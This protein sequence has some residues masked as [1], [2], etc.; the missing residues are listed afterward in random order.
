MKDIRLKLFLLSI[1]VLKIYNLKI[2]SICPP[3][4]LRNC[5]DKKCS[6]IDKS[7]R[8][9]MPIANLEQLKKFSIIKHTLRGAAQFNIIF[10]LCHK[11]F[12]YNTVN[13]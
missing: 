10:S 1:P 2:S 5:F 8:C 7:L 9:F 11:S 13:C 3:Q 4:K 6:N 12:L